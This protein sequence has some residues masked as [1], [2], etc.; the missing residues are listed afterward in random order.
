MKVFNDLTT[1]G[2]RDILVA[3]VDGLKGLPEAIETVFPRTTVQ[4][5]IVHLMRNSLGYVSW[6]DRR[7]VVA[8]L[9]PIYNS[10]TAEAAAVKLIWLAM[11]NALARR[12][13][14]ICD[15]LR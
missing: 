9:R 12:D 1:R 6:K 8:A 4:T 2:V 3:V 5:C 14:T 13:V 7:A 11:R 15:D 10:P